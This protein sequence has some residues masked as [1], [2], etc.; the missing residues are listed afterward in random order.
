M[1][2]AVSRAYRHLSLLLALDVGLI[3]LLASTLRVLLSALRMLNA[4]C[5][6]ALV[7]LL[8]GSAVGLCSI[9]V[10]FGSSIMIVICHF[11][12]LGSLPARS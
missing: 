4:L 8:S 5:V 9:F 10:K 6:I 7:M 11:V 1:G 3:A 2:P 12:P